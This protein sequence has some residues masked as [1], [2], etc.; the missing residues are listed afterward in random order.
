MSSNSPSRPGVPRAPGALPLLGHIPQLL[1][2]PLR[3]LTSLP[4]HGD[5]VQIHLGPVGATVVCDPELTRQVLINDRAFDKG[6]P[7]FT[8]LREVIGDGLAS[9]PHSRHRRQRRLTQP[10][11]HRNRLSTYAEAMSAEVAVVA[12]SW[13]DGHIVDVPRAMMHLSMR[14]LMDTVFSGTLPPTAFQETLDDINTVM[15]GAYRR[16]ILPPLWSRLPTPHNRRYSRANT[17]LQRTVSDVI[18]DRRASGRDLGD[19]LSILLTT[20]DTS[21]GLG[22]T[23]T[24]LREQL[25]TFFMAGAESTATTMAWAL[26][27]L[28]HNPDIENRVHAEVESVLGGAPARWEHLPRLELTGRV[29]LE[30]LRL[31]PPGWMVT[32]TVTTDT[33]LGGHLLPVGANVVYSPYVIHRR[34]DLYSDPT[35]FH[36]DRW[37]KERHQPPPRSAFI[38]F[39]GGARKC[40]GDEFS[41]T[42]TTLALASIIDR[43]RLTELPGQRVRPVASVSLRPLGGMRMRVHARVR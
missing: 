37:D 13:R 14:I 25:V 23:D 24:E 9:C 35:Q 29:V 27:L 32:R 34:D 15:A 40:I 1:R 21:D 39:G 2:D 16:M 38:P 5:L 31:Y 6:G 18:R 43:W 8:R 26:H 7:L 4:A 20:R 12:D 42:E 10:G 22:L 17:R 36:P 3:F 11:F 41:I 30:T 19:L 33:Q 28:A